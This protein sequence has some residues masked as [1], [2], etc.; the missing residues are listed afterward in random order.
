MKTEEMKRLLEKA[1]YMGEC[2]AEVDSDEVEA[3][4]PTVAP[5]VSE[6]DALQ[7]LYDF[8]SEGDAFRA[9]PPTVLACAALLC[10][11]ARAERW[12][13]GFSDSAQVVPGMDDP[14]VDEDYEGLDPDGERA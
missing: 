5:P 10:R 4:F 12:A 11:R 2:W 9:L 7:V 6:E 8:S 1:I 14:R 3:P 13:Q